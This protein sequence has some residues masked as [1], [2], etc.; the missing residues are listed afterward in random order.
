MEFIQSSKD[1]LNLVIAF[2][3][4]LVATF[5]AWFIYYLAMI[6]R[7]LYIIFK[8]TREKIEKVNKAVKDFKEKFEH[9][10]SYVSL[11]SEGIKKI[12]E[13]VKEHSEKKKKKTTEKKK[14]NR[15]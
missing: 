2:S 6:M 7:Q 9:S 4:L 11:I 3:V 12:S 13:V 10:A 8:E 1:I 15:V 14:K 5:F